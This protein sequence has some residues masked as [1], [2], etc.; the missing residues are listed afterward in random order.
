MIVKI[1]P[2][3]TPATDTPAAAASSTIT[4]DAPL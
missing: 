4:V 1:L 2:L 3:D